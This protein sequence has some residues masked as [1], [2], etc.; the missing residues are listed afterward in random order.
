MRFAAV[1][2]LIAAAF[3]LH[4]SAPVESPERASTADVVAP[5]ASRE[6][7]S[8]RA[9]A[10]EEDT[11]SLKSSVPG[12]AEAVEEGTPRVTSTVEDST[13][14]TFVTGTFVGT[15][16]IGGKT[17]A[18]R[19]EKDIFLVKLDRTGRFKWVKA[20]GSSSH[21]RAPRVTLA[22]EDARISVV[23]I[24]EG[25]MDCGNGA[26]KPWATET[27]FFCMFSATDGAPAGSGVFPTG[28]P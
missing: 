12:F 6:E 1:G 2:V 10:E 15:V 4:C 5:P 19:G 8:E 26:M 25:E 27:S 3:G 16:V 14:A 24:T 7:P 28:A 22:V 11:G 20:A 9:V 13:G 18:S 21:E 17:L 23:G